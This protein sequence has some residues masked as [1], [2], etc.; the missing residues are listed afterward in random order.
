VPTYVGAAAGA[1][2]LTPVSIVYGTASLV[3]FRDNPARIAESWLK[4]PGKGWYW[5]GM[6]TGT[7]FRLVKGVAWD[8]PKGIGKLFIRDKEPPEPESDCD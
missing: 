1:V 4:A 8:I 3:V 7:P 5:G 2:A 6:V